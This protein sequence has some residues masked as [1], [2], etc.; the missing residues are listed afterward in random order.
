MFYFFLIIR[1]IIIFLPWYF[2]PRVL[3]LAKAKMYINVYYYYYYYYYF[4]AQW[5]KV[6]KG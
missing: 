2:I 4:Y 1:I 3:Q 6:P 5:C